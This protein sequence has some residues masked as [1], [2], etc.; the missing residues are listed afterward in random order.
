M[1]AKLIA[2][3]LVISAGQVVAGDL[4]L[5]RAQQALKAQ[6]FYYGQ[7]TGEKNADTT[8]A[9][10]RFQI[11]S[12]LKVTGELNQET[13]SALGENRSAETNPG[14]PPPTPVPQA[15][16]TE[17]EGVRPNLTVAPRPRGSVLA[18]TPFAT[19][20]AS[21]QQRVIASA[22]TLMR[23][24][25][26]YKG[27]INGVVDPALEFSLRAYQ[28]NFG[29]KP[30]GRL[31]LETLAALGLLPGQRSPAVFRPG[32]IY[33][34]QPLAQPPVRGEWIPERAR[35]HDEDD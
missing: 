9:I 24:Q 29:L 8:A 33:P 15:T 12:G 5:E 20:P 25:G 23:Q 27:A 1:K 17:Q 4:A 34:P 6:G 2:G 26:Y 22:Q 21:L 14:R 32:R 16:S 10:R 28:S 3:I 11:R 19:A 7:V 13:L 18:N 35:P 30:T 31:D